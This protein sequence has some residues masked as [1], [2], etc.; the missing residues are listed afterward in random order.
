MTRLTTILLV[1][2]TLF[3]ATGCTMNA[4]QYQPDFAVVNDLKD[5]ETK[6]MAVGDITSASK[7]VD[8]ISIRGSSMNSPFNGSYSDYLENALK[9]Q[10][11]HAGL[12]DASSSV[13]ISG[14]LQQNDLNA[15]GFSIGKA[16]LSAKFVVKRDGEEVYSGVKSVHHEWPSSFVGA[17]AI[18]NAVN[19]YP[20]AVQ[21]LVVE[22]LSDEEFL[23][24][25]K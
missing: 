18:P 7:K 21:K 20:T 11:S 5:A 16:D 23:A 9:E 3:M 8:K 24:A 13:V 6:V 2:F 12:F 22:L 14:E 4:V 17:V 15:A 10:L 25:V 19:N 1:A